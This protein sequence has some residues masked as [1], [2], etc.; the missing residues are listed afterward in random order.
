MR[1][2]LL[3]AI[4]FSAAALAACGSS[5]ETASSGAGGGGST[6]SGAGASSGTGST[7]STGTSTSST[8][9]DPGELEADCAK[10]CDVIAQC[11][12]P[13][14]SCEDDCVGSYDSNPSCQPE[15]AAFVHCIAGQGSS[16]DCENPTGGACNDE[17]NALQGCGKPTAC[18]ADCSESSGGECDC[19]EDCIGESWASACAPDGKGGLS[20]KCT[21]DGQA[22]GTCT[23][24]G[25]GLDCCQQ[26]FED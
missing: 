20:C 15:Y 8:G 19:V 17:A 4:G 11:S 6:A 1:T 18:E 10:A 22:V 25:C 2:C 7:G 9:V 13:S 14:P 5:V 3:L 12:S 23:Q 16:V 24:V 21:V 26:F